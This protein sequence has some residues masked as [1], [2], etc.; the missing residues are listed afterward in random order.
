MS[1]FATPSPWVEDV[2][3]LCVVALF[4]GVPILLGVVAAVRYL[5]TGK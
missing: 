3:V 1:L 4:L 2:I 5:F